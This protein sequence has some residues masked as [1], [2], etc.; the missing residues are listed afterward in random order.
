MPPVHEIN[1]KLATLY[2]DYKSEYGLAGINKMMTAIKRK[3]WNISKQQLLDFLRS[4]KAYTLHAPRKIRMKRQKI[5]AFGVEHNLQMDLADMSS[6]SRVNGGIKFL[7]I[8][9]I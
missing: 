1:K 8:M 7:C 2:Y 9:V 5:L 4:Q 3:K 6:L